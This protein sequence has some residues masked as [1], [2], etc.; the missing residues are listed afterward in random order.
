MKEIFLL[1]VKHENWERYQFSRN[2][3]IKTD[4]EGDVYNVE[5]VSTHHIAFVDYIEKDGEYVGVKLKYNDGSGYDS[6]NYGYTVN[7]MVGESF[8][9]S[10]DGCWIDDEGC[11][12]D[13]EIKFHL[14]LSPYEK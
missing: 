2:A 9:F 14:T 4:E 7:L 8:D 6:V 1:R 5:E 11:P 13:F 3:L 10:Y 12:E